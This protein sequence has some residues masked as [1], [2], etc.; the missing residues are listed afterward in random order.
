MAA[1]ASISPRP[2]TTGNIGITSMRVVKRLTVQLASR[3]CFF[4]ISNLGDLAERSHLSDLKSERYWR[5][6]FVINQ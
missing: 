6:S 2:N 5:L 3:S 1:A 4:R